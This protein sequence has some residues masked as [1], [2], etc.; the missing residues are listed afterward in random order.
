MA[1]LCLMLVPV[2]ALCSLGLCLLLVRQGPRLGL[3][4]RPGSEGHKQSD[5]SVPTVGG[6]GMFWAIALPMGAILGAA[7]RM[8]ADRWTG[9]LS[10]MS[11]HV[12][13]LRQ[14]SG[15]GLAILGG[16]AVMHATGLWDDRHRLSA[17]PKL[18]LQLAVAATLVGAFDVRVLHV[19]DQWGPIGTAVSLGISVIWIVAITNA[20]NMLDNMDGLSAGV[21]AIIALVY[22][23]A[24]LIGGQWFIAAL[25][26]LLLGA[27]LGFL[28]LNYPPA[29]IYMGDA[30]SLVI[31]LML[32]IISVRT[33]YVPAGE[34]TAALSGGG[35]GAWH[36][37]LMP[38]MV[39]AVPLYDFV[40]VTLIRAVSGQSPFVGDTNHFSHRLVRMGLTRRGAVAV[41]WLATAAT[42]ISGMMLATLAPWQAG[43]AALQTAAVLATLAILERSASR[44][45]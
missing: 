29:T 39:M 10:P 9:W 17:G 20:M 8:P 7:W 25:A 41:I 2:S 15:L 22:L 12:A 14:T 3:V 13:G 4:D 24:T 1:Y 32:A 43:L 37:T 30:G 33:T 44:G 11:D 6:V 21:A 27:C 23:V 35:G 16:L 40:S 42:A 45:S 36:A 28:C 26:A 34:A 5:R 18:A 19:L 38:L 31:G